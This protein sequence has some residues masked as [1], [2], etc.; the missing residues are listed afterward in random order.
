MPRTLGES[1]IHIREIDACVET[2]EPVIA[3]GHAALTDAHHCLAEQVSTLIDDGTTIQLGI[4][5]VADA[6]L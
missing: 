6:V 5:A 2:V 1:S 3:V 4:G